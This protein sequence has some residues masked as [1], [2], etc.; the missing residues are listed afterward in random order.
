M[1]SYTD[2]EALNQLQFNNLFDS[3]LIKNLPYL[4]WMYELIDNDYKLIKWN[5]NQEIYTEYSAEELY[6]MRPMDFFKKEDEERIIKGIV[7]IFNNGKVKLFGDLKTK[8]G[9]LIPY[10]FEGYQ[11]NF[12]NRQIFIGISVDVS[13]QAKTI[14]KLQLYEKE[15]QDLL[16]ENNEKKDQLSNVTAQIFQNN[17]LNN[18]LDRQVS[19]ILKSDN[20]DYIKNELIQLNKIIKNRQNSQENWETYNIKLEASHRDFLTKLKTIH[21]CLTKSELRF[22]AYVK[23]QIPISEIASFLNISMDGIKKK[24]YRIRKKFNLKRNDSLNLYI[25][26]L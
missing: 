16:V 5:K 10:Y 23:I 24:K 6:H 1:Q 8:A 7:T 21:P 26:D 2:I 12:S 14:R 13:L 4:F 17:R 25:S 22:C 11:F 9:K 19:K 18:I 3:T 15:K 20:I